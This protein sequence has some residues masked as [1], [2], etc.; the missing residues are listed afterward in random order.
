MRQTSKVEFSHTSIN[1]YHH[2]ESAYE[3][4]MSRYFSFFFCI[5]EYIKTC[6][7]HRT[8]MKRSLYYDLPLNDM[9]N[10]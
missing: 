5:E 8:K 2:A 9:F 6:D 1:C 4:I 3:T 7:F 10:R